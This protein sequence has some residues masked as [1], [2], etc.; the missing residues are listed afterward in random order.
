MAGTRVANIAVVV[1]LFAAAFTLADAALGTAQQDAYWCP[2]HPGVRSPTPG[3]CP[4][5]AMTLVAIRAPAI[6]E[7]RM[8]VNVMPTAQGRGLRGLR[9][10]LRNPADGAPVTDLVTVHEKPLHLFVISRDLTY[11]AHA[12]P[13][14]EGSGTFLLKHELPPGE[15]V[16]IADFLPATSTAQMVHR[17]IVSP[18]LRRSLI[19]LAVTPPKPDIP[20]ASARA[21]GNPSSGAAEIIVDGVRVRLEAAD[22]VGGQM[23]LLRFHLFNASDGTPI[24]DLEPYLGAAGHVL[25]ANTSLT[26]AVHGH[27]EEVGTESSTITF[28]PFLPG[29]GIAKLWLQ[30]QR[31]GNVTTA[32]FVIEIQEP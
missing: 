7:Y 12:H 22:L 20:D 18:G 8:E 13:E 25:L 15:Y 30:F 1:L 27:P 5:C 31:R 17:A 9:L 24:R 3:K 21:S 16:V 29:A 14:E 26:D 23:A 4:L 10:R 11:F 28:R 19:P 2:M 6:G 32:P